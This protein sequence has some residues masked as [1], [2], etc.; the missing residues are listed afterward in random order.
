MFVRLVPVLLPLQFLLMASGAIAV[1]YPELLNP[2]ISR[3]NNNSQ[4]QCTLQVFYASEGTQLVDIHPVA[5]P[6]PVLKLELVPYGMHCYFGTILPPATP[7]T[8]CEWLTNPGHNPQLTGACRLRSANSWA[9]D[10]S[11]TCATATTWG[12]HSGA[13]PGGECIVFAQSGQNRGKTLVT[14]RGVLQADAAA[15]AGSTFCQKMMPPA[16][17]CSVD[18]PPVIDHGTI[19]PTTTMSRTVDGTVDCGANPRITFLGGEH[20]VLGPGVTAILTHTSDR[21]GNLRI[22]SD[23]TAKDA[24]PGNHQTSVVVSVSPY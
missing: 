18:L 16:V 6:S 2:R 5:P 23:L 15:N 22:T 20:I 14:P 9:L 7:F 17:S 8:D 13:G 12:P 1:P 4:G 24:T 21:G 10:S 11:S 19:A 3:C